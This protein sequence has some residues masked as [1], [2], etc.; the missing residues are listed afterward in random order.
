MI[1][2]DTWGRAVA[3]ALQN[4]I[5][6]E[7]VDAR[8]GERFDVLDPATGEV[9]ATAPN[10]KPVDV[11][12]RGRRRPP[13]VRRGRVV[14]GDAR[15]RTRPDPPRRGRHRPSRARAAGAH[16]VARLRQA[17]RRRAATTSPRSPTCS[18]TSAAGRP[19]SRATSSTS[20][21]D[22]MFMVWKEP[23]GVAAGITPWNYPM[24]MAVAEARARD[25]GGLHLHP[26]AARADAAH[27]RCELPKILEEAGLPA[28]VF[29][30]LTGL[31]RD[32]GRPARRATRRS[33]R[34]G[35]PGRARWARSSCARAPRRSSG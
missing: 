20:S 28:G 23:M 1:V 32:R 6:G 19:R 8:D 13:R 24:M 21:P 25:R 33:T 35:S 29:H 22:A 7:W 10:S 3:D 30:V 11:D 12:A 31:R 26:Q 5:D 9:I 16:G 14:A 2:Q 4:F 27:L 15:P 34:S 17:D 18:S